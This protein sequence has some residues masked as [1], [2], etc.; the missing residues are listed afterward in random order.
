MLFSINIIIPTPKSI[1]N[2][3]IILYSKNTDE[4][5]KT[6]QSREFSIPYV[7]G[8]VEAVRGSPNEMM[9]ITSIPSR[10]KPLI[11]SK[12]VI[13]ELFNLISFSNIY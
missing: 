3:P 12:F 4:I 9:L 8:F 6:I 11:K 7:E 13:L 1:E 5:I 2:N 10:E